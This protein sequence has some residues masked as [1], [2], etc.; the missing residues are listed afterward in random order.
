MKMRR[1]L[2]I[3][4]LVPLLTVGVSTSQGASATVLQRQPPLSAPNTPAH[5]GGA[6]APSAG[7]TSSPDAAS[8]AKLPNQIH[9][10]VN[11]QRTQHGLKVLA[12][13]SRVTRAAVLHTQNMARRGI[14]SH[15]IDGKGPADRLRDQGA[16]FSASGE[17]IYI[18]SCQTNGK[19][20]WDA[21][22]FARNAVTWWMKSPGHRANILKSD[23]NYTGVGVWAFAKDG[24]GWIYTTQVFIKR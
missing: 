24:V 12:V 1:G 19:P 23:F 16:S 15:V 21:E 9:S 6:Q 13:D 10:L 20:S 17:N 3:A 22:G 14:V 7:C 8:L 2:A 18:R 4:S 5:T 11:E